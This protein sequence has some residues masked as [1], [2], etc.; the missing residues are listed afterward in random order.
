MSGL[1]ATIT[2]REILDSRGNPTVE[3]EVTLDNGI[4]G[5]GAA[6]SGAST[7]SHE[8]WELRDNDKS[9]FHGKG[10][11]TAVDNVNEIIAPVLAGTDV[12]D[13]LAL[14]ASLTGL[15]DSPR[16][17][18]I[19]ANAI[20]AV[21]IAAVKAASQYCDL[22]LW[23]YLGGVGSRIVPVPMMNILNGGAHADNGVD[24]QEFM[25]MP[26]GL[27]T[28]SDALRAGSEVF[29]SLKRILR[30]RNMSSGVG[31]EGGFAPRLEHNEDALA[32]LVAAIE[33]AGYVPGSEIGIALDIAASELCHT[34]ASGKPEKSRQT[35]SSLPP[36]KKN[37]AYSFEGKTLTAG[38]FVEILADWVDRFPIISIED[39]CAE[40]DWDGWQLLTEAL[41]NRIQLVGDD[42]FVTNTE[43]IQMGI[44]RGIANAVLI[45]PNQIGTVSETLLAVDL[46]QRNGYEAVVSHRSGETDDTFIAD[47]AVATN[48]GQIKTG[49]PSRG[50]RIVKYNQLLRIESE[51]GENAIYAGEFWE[52]EDV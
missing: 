29:H 25:I 45:K 10:V 8:A 28:F 23:R 46:A 3:A 38:E 14:D 43:R 48:C 1:I 5:R 37:F 27:P 13:Q 4:V 2:A 39:G 12:L 16:K 19:G 17:K 20:L 36:P 32:L 22:P 44:E 47:L 51:L 11:C 21:S 18:R 31:D 35:R 41:A 34:I 40:D 24:V 9:R 30:E 49:A 15:D 50:E 52:S 7:G 42:L 26:I 6:P 33:K